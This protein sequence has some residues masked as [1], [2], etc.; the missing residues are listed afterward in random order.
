QEWLHV[1]KDTLE[2]LPP[3]TVTEETLGI[4]GIRLANHVPGKPVALDFRPPE[5]RMFFF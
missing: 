1:L 4:K 5:V 2:E 3:S